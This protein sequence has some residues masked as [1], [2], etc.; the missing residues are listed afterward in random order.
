MV[1]RKHVNS[2]LINRKFN[3]LI[4]PLP[5]PKYG[6]RRGLES[7]G[8]QWRAVLLLKAKIRDLNLGGLAHPD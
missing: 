1:K 8:K 3:G 2:F 7:A 6:A 5:F 4:I